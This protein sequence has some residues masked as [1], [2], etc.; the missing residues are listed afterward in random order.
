MLWIAGD[1]TMYFFKNVI[2]DET[3]ESTDA[4]T[5]WFENNNIQNIVLCGFNDIEW[6]ELWD[7]EVHTIDKKWVT[8]G[9]CGDNHCGDSD[10][11]SESE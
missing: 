5:L 8:E 3:L 6:G 10:T 7:T 1:G 4:F 9:Y 2:F 11:E